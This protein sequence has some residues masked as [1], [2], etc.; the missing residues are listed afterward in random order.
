[1]LKA[2]LAHPL[3]RD[4]DIDDPSVTHLRRRIIQEKPSAAPQGLYQN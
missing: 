2:W 1:M 4:V 3:T